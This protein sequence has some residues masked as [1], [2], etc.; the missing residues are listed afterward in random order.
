MGLWD[1]LGI[2][3]GPQGPRGPQGPQGLTGEGDTGPQG[4]LGL[5]GSVGSQGPIGLTG[6]VGSQGSQGP[7][8][9]VG[10]Q[11]PQGPQGNNASFLFPSSELQNPTC[12]DVYSV[13]QKSVQVCI[14][15]HDSNSSHITNTLL[16]E[17]NH[18]DTNFTSCVNVPLFSQLADVQSVYI[19]GDD[20]PNN[21][22][23][24]SNIV[25][26]SYA[27]KAANLDT[28]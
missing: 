15:N 6:S 19:C 22:F 4:P 2:Q 24:L 17:Q 3:E 12:G 26:H 11:G 23:Q 21:M 27:T 16:G 1:F 7:Q 28:S 8:G 13:N 10:P 9:L 14:E 18:T 20:T 25:A 5:T